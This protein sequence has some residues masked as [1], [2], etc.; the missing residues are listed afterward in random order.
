M[1]ELVLVLGA[2]QRLAYV[3]K[4]VKFCHCMLAKMSH[5][6]KIRTRKHVMTGT[7]S[8]FRSNFMLIAA[9]PVG[10]KF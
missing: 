8:G 1:A 2:F 9:W 7:S 10:P 4:G 3:P 6:L 5:F